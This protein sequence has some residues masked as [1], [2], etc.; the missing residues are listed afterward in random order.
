MSSITSGADT[1]DAITNVTLDV[2]HEPAHKR[3]WRENKEKIQARRALRPKAPLRPLNMESVR[4][5]R[6]LQVQIKA[7]QVEAKKYVDEVRLMNRRGRSV[8]VPEV[9]G[10]AEISE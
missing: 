4:K 8:E 6:E 5:Y 3:Y 9:T 10:V 2:I 1:D 7:L